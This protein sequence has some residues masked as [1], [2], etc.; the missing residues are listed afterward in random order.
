MLL[1]ILL[2]NLRQQEEKKLEEL[3]EFLKMFMSE[4]SL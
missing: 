3:E 4:E 1:K 2:P